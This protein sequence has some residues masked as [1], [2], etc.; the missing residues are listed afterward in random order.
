MAR[1]RCLHRCMAFGHP[2]GYPG[3]ELKQP[4]LHF[5]GNCGYH[6]IVQYHLEGEI[7]VSR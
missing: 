2:W 5:I 7:I 4:D 1:G 6:Y 3:Y